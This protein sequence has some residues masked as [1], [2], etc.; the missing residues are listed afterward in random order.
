LQEGVNS[1]LSQLGHFAGIKREIHPVVAAG[2][3]FNFALGK[4][5]KEKPARAFHLT[6]LAAKR[7]D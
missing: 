5:G 6:S 3:D 4:K 1:G 7:N 2:R